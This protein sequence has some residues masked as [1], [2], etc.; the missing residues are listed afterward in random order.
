MSDIRA[1]LNLRQF[2]LG[3]PLGAIAQAGQAAAAS[4]AG[5]YPQFELWEILE[6]YDGARYTVRNPIGRIMRKV[7][8]VGPAAD[9]LSVGQVVFVG[10]YDRDR[11]KPYIKS[12]GGYATW[13]LPEEALVLALWAQPEA[14]CGLAYFAAS[15]IVDPDG[16]STTIFGDGAVNGSAYFGITVSA[17][18]LATFAQ[19]V[20]NEANTAWAKMRLIDLNLVATI[21]DQPYTFTECDISSSPALSVT[22]DTFLSGDRKFTLV[23]NPGIVSFPG[24]RQIFRRHRDRF[25]QITLTNLDTLTL[26]AASVSPLGY[27]AMPAYAKHGADSY[28]AHI[29][30]A[31]TT[32]YSDVTM[33]AEHK[34]SGWQT[35]TTV[36]AV[37]RAWSVDSAEAIGYSRRV[38]FT[39]LGSYRMPVSL[40]GR[41]LVSWASTSK[42][43]DRTELDPVLLGYP[44]ITSGAD[45]FYSFRLDISR[46]LKAGLIGLSGVDGSASWSHI[47]TATASQAVQDEGMLVPIEDYFGTLS[48]LDF[49]DNASAVYAGRASNLGLNNDQFQPFASFW[50]GTS[51]AYPDYGYFTGAAI[52]GLPKPALSGDDGANKTKPFYV[53]GA[54]DTLGVFGGYITANPSTGDIQQDPRL[55]GDEFGNFYLAY[56]VPVTYLTP[57]GC[58]VVEETRYGEWKGSLVGAIDGNNL[59]HVPGMINCYRRYIRKVSSTGALLASVE[60]EQEYTASWR[61]LKHLINQALEAGPDVLS[62]DSTDPWP[63]ADNI[64]SLHPCGNVVFCFVDYHDL[65]PTYSPATKL[66]IRAAADLSLLHTIELR[67]ADDVIASDVLDE[68]S[69]VAYYA[70]DRRYQVQGL[71]LH[72]RTGK[73]DLGEWALIWVTQTDVTDAS[74]SSRMILVEMVAGDIYATPT[75]TNPTYSPP[76]NTAIVSNGHILQPETIG[77]IT[78]INAIG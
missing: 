33:T 26:N 71:S 24:D 49:G 5:K 7:P 15:N 28:G 41:S 14:S 40:D 61:A 51:V 2:E 70:G 55:F 13:D 54:L 25:E 66:E 38:V 29:M 21:T 17:T 62:S 75:V 60:I 16:S 45:V 48:G 30:A 59:Y 67:T 64:W 19:M 43:M 9:R 68:F 50:M 32:E 78:V 65:G 37:P 46:E 69:Q 8:A 36:T 52:F 34:V 56:L 58:G 76:S 27:L 39:N 23:I 31:N 53:I 77:S 74:T 11:H 1:Q 3:L 72:I 73:K 6:K 35:K 4:L 44:P 42:V 47:I 18:G 57:G 10:Y 22:G 63:L 20:P 12:A